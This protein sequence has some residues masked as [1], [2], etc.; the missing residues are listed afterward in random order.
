ME[1]H[2]HLMSI[3]LVCLLCFHGRM[4]AMSNKCTKNYLSHNAIWTRKRTKKLPVDQ[5]TVHSRCF[6][7]YIASYLTT[8]FRV[9][10]L[11]AG[12]IDVIQW[13][14]F[15][16]NVFLVDFESDIVRQI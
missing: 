1:F 16:F 5:L 8:S 13:L 15:I 14:S 7:R 11:L 4:A 6:A 9:A 2:S 3:C 12:E 10:S